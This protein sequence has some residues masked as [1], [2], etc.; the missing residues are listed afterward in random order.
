MGTP[1]SSIDLADG[2]DETE[3][4][5]GGS[6]VLPGPPPAGEHGGASLVMV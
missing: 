1:F 4:V 3:N 5:K 2:A 6:K